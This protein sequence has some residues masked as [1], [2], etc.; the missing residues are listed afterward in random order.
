[1]K[2]SIIGVG[3]MGGTIARNIV[4]GGLFE[5]SDLT[6]CDIDWGKIEALEAELG[7]AG[8]LDK[9]EA[10]A[11]ADAII[12]AVKPQVMADALDGLDVRE[13]QLVVSIAAGITLKFLE[14]ALEGRRVVRVMPNTPC[15]V[16]E[17]MSAYALGSLA[18]EE[19]GEF[20][21]RVF[22]SLGRVVRLEEKYLDAVTGLSGSGPAYVYLFIEAL[23]D[24]GVLLGLPRD[25]S[26]LLA[27]QT[28]LGSARMVLESG[29]HPMELK[30]MVTSPGGTTIAAI[31][32]LERW[33]FRGIV[34]DAVAAAARRA[35]E[36]GR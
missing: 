23:A 22:S 26:R 30:D 1:M 28:V 8:T 18:T 4:R 29:K 36:L 7:V 6:V 3:A 2:V 12:L 16:R 11:G 15:L 13:D 24:A 9:N 35:E 31:Q 21:S 20:V 25:V 5:P 14:S 17:G 10:I 27:A 32:V 33:G 34:M 19:D